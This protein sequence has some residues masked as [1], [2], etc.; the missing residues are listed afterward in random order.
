M[1]EEAMSSSQVTHD[2]SP[3]LEQVLRREAP[4]LRALPE[5]A[6][7]VRPGGGDT[8]SP[9][10]ELGHLIDSAAN[11][12]V[13]FVRALIES[14]FRGPSYAQ[15][16]WVQV[17]RYQEMPWAAIVDFWYRYNK[18]LIGLLSHIPETKLRTACYVGADGGVSL[19]FLVGDYVLHMQHHVDHLLGREHV[20][21]YPAPASVQAYP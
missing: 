17:H 18:F 9:K 21:P 1:I 12:H 11:N 3:A 5:A 2:L 16:A 15:N 19:Q 8:W 20:T 13:R 10:E 4:L 7:E 6:A 14:E